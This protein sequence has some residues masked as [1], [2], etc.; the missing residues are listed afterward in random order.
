[1]S[2]L[3]IAAAASLFVFLP[4]QAFTL[5]WTHSVEK[6]RWEEDWRVESGG[7]RIVE[8]RIRG[9]G[10]GMEPPAG[11]ILENGVWRYVP[12]LKPV[13]RLRLANSDFTAAY[14]LCVEHRCRPLAE[15]ADDT[16]N[17]PLEIYACEGK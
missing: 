10:A 11:A 14:E 15:L 4:L 13:E 2:G 7:L 16:E 9:S 6:V 8:A 17:R 3:C 5:A 12:R 1:M